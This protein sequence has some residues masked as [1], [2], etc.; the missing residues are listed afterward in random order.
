M[1]RVRASGT[2]LVFLINSCLLPRWAQSSRA[3]N[4]T[5]IAEVRSSS[6]PP[7]ASTRSAIRWLCTKNLFTFICDWLFLLVLR[8]SFGAQT[9][10]GETGAL[11]AGLAG[12]TLLLAATAWLLVRFAGV[13]DDARTVLLLVVLM[14]LATSVTFDDVLVRDPVL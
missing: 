9:N 10:A 1:M 11:M 4:M 2:S 8:I 13:W 6:G 7:L 3:P 5:P 12:Y 14:F